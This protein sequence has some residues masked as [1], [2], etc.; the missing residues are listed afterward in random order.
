MQVSSK[1][2]IIA[3]ALLAA[4]PLFGQNAISVKAGMVNVADGEV[5]LAGKAV[6]PKGADIIQIAAGDL[7]R[8]GEGRAEILLTPGAFLRMPDQSSFSLDRTGLDDV[9]LTLTGG[10]ALIEVAELLDSNSITVKLNDAEISLSKAGLYRFTFDPAN[11]R[12]YEGEAVVRTSAGEQRLKKSRQLTESAGVWQAGRFD[13]DETDALFRWSR[14]RSEYVAMA[15][16]SSARM[17]S[18]YVGS[19]GGRTSGWL[20]NPYFGTFTFIPMFGNIGS[21]FGYYYYSPFLIYR[22]Y[23]PPQNPIYAGGGGGG[24]NASSGFGRGA[25]GS[26]GGVSTRSSS[27]SYSAIRGDS[28]GSAGTVSSSSASSGP[29]FSGGGSHTS[30]TGSSR[31]GG[32]Q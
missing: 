28:K 26:G 12:V 23:E 2:A 6:E 9:R 15:N 8:T 16:R 21:P 7:L 22:A 32:K 4:A 24:S 27:E 14:R 31:G 13:T 19:W 10:S 11:I 29:M 30:S 25:F 3:I 20:F 1:T 17:A 5:Y 18:S